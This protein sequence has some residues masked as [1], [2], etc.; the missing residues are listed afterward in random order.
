MHPTTRLPLKCIAGRLIG[1]AL[2]TLSL[3]GCA[4]VA[5]WERG[6]LAK[7][8]MAVDPAPMRSAMRSMACI[9]RPSGIGRRICSTAPKAAL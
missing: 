7:P 8:H 3:A 2:A 4:D 1:A 6:T 9:S 5:P